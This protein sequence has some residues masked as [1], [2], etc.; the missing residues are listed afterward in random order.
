MGILDLRRDPSEEA[1]GV[2]FPRDAPDFGDCDEFWFGGFEAL[3]SRRR[4]N[5]SLF[6]MN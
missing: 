4:R 3:S 5:C 1:T 6:M 2:A